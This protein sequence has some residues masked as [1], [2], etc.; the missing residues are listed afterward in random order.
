[1]TTPRLVAFAL[2][3]LFLAATV[4][5]FA[6]DEPI[7]WGTVK[8]TVLWK[9]KDLPKQQKIDVKGVTE[10]LKNGDLYPESL[11]IDPKTKGV[12]WVYVWL[13]PEDAKVK[14]PIHKDLI[15]IKDKEK[16][17]VLDQPCCQF[18]PHN[19]ALRQGQTLVIKNSAAIP[20]NVNIQGPGGNP[21]LN[22]A[23]APGSELEVDGWIAHRLPIQIGCNVHPWMNGYIRVFN[24]PYYAVTDE[25]GASRSKTPPP[26]RIASSPGKT[27]AGSSA[28]AKKRPLGARP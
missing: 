7:G 5:S 2:S 26:A 19:L 12:R 3:L 17:V 18:V 24:H 4:T 10:C 23:V 6:A 14:L 27:T 11:V 9:S 15:D 16:K 25:K 22:K 1:M 8:G 20:H 21:E 13:I 28:K